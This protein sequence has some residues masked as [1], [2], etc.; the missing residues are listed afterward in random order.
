MVIQ[1]VPLPESYRLMNH[2][3]RPWFLSGRLLL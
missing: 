2:S 3:L 1:S